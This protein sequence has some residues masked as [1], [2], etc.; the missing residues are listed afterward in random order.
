M[1]SSGM[2]VH[3][4]TYMGKVLKCFHVH[5]SHPFNSLIVV[6]SLELNKNMFD[7]NEEDEELLGPKLPYFSVIDTMMYLA[8]CI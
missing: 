4:L 3:L 5:K 8:N 6:L 2:L 1:F 7:P